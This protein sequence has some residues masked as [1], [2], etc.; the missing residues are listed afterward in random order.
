MPRIKVVIPSTG[1][2][3]LKTGLDF[4]NKNSMITDIFNLLIN[5]PY[6]RG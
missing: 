2:I 6:T 5:F 4:I 1:I 3:F